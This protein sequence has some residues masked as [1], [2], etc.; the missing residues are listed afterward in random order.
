MGFDSPKIKVN[1]AGFDQT[2]QTAQTSFSAISSEPHSVTLHSAANDGAN[3]IPFTQ[4]EQL[5]FTVTVTIEELEDEF[6]CYRYCYYHKSQETASGEERKPQ[7][8]YLYYNTQQANAPSAPSSSGV[9]YTWATGLMSGGVIGTGATN[10]NQIAPTATGGTSDSKM[11]Y[12]YYNVVHN[13]V[14]NDNATSAVTFG[15]VVY[16][17]TN[18]TGLV[19]FNG[20]NAVEM[21]LEMD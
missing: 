12:V 10:W 8:G 2:D 9:A 3:P 17:A 20:T 15:T 21:V 13:D 7:T 18:F 14:Q 11:W 1:G 5:V 4:E 6:N 19:R 16:A